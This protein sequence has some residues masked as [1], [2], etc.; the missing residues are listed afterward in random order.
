MAR[1]KRRNLNN[2]HQDHL[3]SSEPS[4]STK[5]NTEYPNTTEKQD[6]D[7]K[8]LFMIMME[9][10]KKDLNNPRKEMQNNTSKQ[11]EALKEET[12]KSLKE[13]QEN[14]TKQ[15]KELNKTIQDLKMEIEATKKAKRETTLEI[16]NQRKS[17][18]S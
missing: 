9:D 11:V 7:L 2:R 13:L 17:K 1:G 6:L 4:S 12:Q 8:P 15:M 3:A 18:E 16:E 10:L 14:T 5:E